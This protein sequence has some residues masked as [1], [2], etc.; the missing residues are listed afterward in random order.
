MEIIVKINQAFI[1]VTALQKS[2]V[3]I[4]VFTMMPA[5][6]NKLRLQL[7]KIVANLRSL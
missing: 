4:K 2:K 1:V 5:Q 6:E 3:K 7:T